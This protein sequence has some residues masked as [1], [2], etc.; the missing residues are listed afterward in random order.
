MQ[1]LVQPGSPPSSRSY[2]ACGT[3]SQLLWHS[4]CTVGSAGSSSD[5]TSCAQQKEGGDSITVWGES[6]SCQDPYMWHW[7]AG[8]ATQLQPAISVWPQSGRVLKGQMAFTLKRV[9][10]KPGECAG[11]RGCLKRKYTLPPPL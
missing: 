6:V 8:A 1:Q 5:C 4:P 10:G 7:I 3:P 9:K 11:L 2:A